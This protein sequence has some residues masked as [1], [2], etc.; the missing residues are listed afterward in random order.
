MKFYNKIM[1][2]FW[3]FA[4]ILIFIV[5]TYLSISE[6]FKK[7]AF[8]YVFAFLAF[9]A[10]ITRKWMMKRMEKHIQFLEEQKKAENK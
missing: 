10:F 5:I 7:W 3:L 6:G 4:A 2:Y 1:L 8:Y 9:L